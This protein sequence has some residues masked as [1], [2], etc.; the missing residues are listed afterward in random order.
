M[1]RLLSFPLGAAGLLV[2]WL[3]LNQA[4]SLGHVLLGGIVALIGLWAFTALEPPPAGK[5]RRLGAVLRLASLVSID[6]VKSNIAVGRIILGLTGRER[7]SGF[8]TIPLELRN[9]YG[10][11]ALACIITATPGTLWVSFDDAKA[12]LLI[13]VLDLV[14]ESDWLRTINGRYERLLLEIFE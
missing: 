11:A 6:V 5:A 2:L 1:R 8:V 13:H 14:D 9:P 3:L 10:L 7:R 12:T 4:L